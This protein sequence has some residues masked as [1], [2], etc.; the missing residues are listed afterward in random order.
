MLTNEEIIEVMSKPLSGDR[1]PQYREIYKLSTGQD[2]SGCL[3][4]SGATRLFQACTAY[5]NAIKNNLNKT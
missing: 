1:V 3:C 4:G 2:F 5:A